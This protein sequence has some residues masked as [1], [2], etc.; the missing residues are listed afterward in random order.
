MSAVWSELS[1]YADCMRPDPDSARLVRMQRVITGYIPVAQLY[2]DG[3]E[4]LHPD[5]ISDGSY[6]G[7]SRR[8]IAVVP[9]QLA[10]RLANVAHN[11][12]NGQADV[13]V[14]RYMDQFVDYSTLIDITLEEENELRQSLGAPATYPTNH[15]LLENFSK[16]PRVYKLWAPMATT[17]SLHSG[18]ATVEF[19]DNFSS[20]LISVGVKDMETFKVEP[21]PTPTETEPEAKPGRLRQFL[22]LFFASSGSSSSWSSGYSTGYG[23]YSSD[24]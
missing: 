22:G 16:M 24:Y 19:R 6:A 4:F 7:P 20:L 10:E 14:R 3:I 17:V 13:A 21:A 11:A 9:S 5:V 18:Q 8:K 23:M 2:D 1:H 12:P 15:L